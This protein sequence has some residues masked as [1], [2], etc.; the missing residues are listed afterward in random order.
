MRS[1]HRVLDAQIPILNLALN[2][3]FLRLRVLPLSNTSEISLSPGSEFEL[4]AESRVE[5][6]TGIEETARNE[7]HVTPS[8]RERVR[9]RMGIFP[10]FC[11]VE[12]SSTASVDAQREFWDELPKARGK[13]TFCIKMVDK[14]FVKQ[15]LCAETFLINP[16]LS[17]DD[18]IQRQL[19]ENVLFHISQ[20]RGE[21]FSQTRDILD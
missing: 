10:F 3:L 17:R 20:I 12:K 14:H 9:G 18:Q 11:L 6:L 16:R 15:R 21:N 7:I 1:C 13:S 5:C 8:R 19:Q 4:H 2:T